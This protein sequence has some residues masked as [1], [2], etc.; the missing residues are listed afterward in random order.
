MSELTH[1]P[2]A[3]VGIGCRFPGADDH[4]AFWRNVLEGRTAF[5]PVPK[6]RWDHRAFFSASQRE[7]D[8]TW[9]LQGAFIDDVRSFAALHYGI[10]PRRIEVMDPQHRLL[11]EA[12]RIAM[13]DAGYELRSFDRSRTGVFTGLT[14]AEFKNL[15]L[16]RIG[17]MQ[18][19]SGEFGPAAGSKELRAILMEMARNVV[20]LRAFSI[21]GSLTNMAAASIAQTFDFGGPAYSI[22]AACAAGAVSI[23]DAII[24]LRAGLLDTAFAGGAY[25]NLTPDNLI[26][27]ARVGA[28]SPSGACRP[29]DHRADG[30]VQGDGVGVLMLKRLDDALEAGD[31]IYGVIRGVGCNNDARGEG[32]MTPRVEGQLGA[33]IAAYRDARV[34]PSTVAYFE[35][36]GTATR[37]GDPVEV[38]ALGQL[39]RDAGVSA[40]TAPL[41]GSVKGNIGHTMSAAGVA[42]LINGLKMLEHR[43][44]PPLAGYET[45]HPAI[46]LERWPLRLQRQASEL[47]AQDGGPLRVGV[48]AFGFG[49]TNVHFVVDE[50]PE[51]YRR[52]RIRSTTGVET[53]APSWPEAVVVT[54]PSLDLLARHAEDLAAAIAGPRADTATLAEIAW[55]LNATRR[56]ERMRLVVT[57]RDREQLARELREAATLLRA[58]PGLRAPAKLSPH[59]QLFEGPEG[60]H[61]P[62]PKLCFLFPGQGAQRVGLLRDLRQRLPRFA[63]AFA[64]LEAACASVTPRPLS[65][66]LWPELDPGDARALAEAEDALTATE[67]CQPAMAAL[68]L[69]LSTV[70]AEAGVTADVSLGHSLGEFVAMANG[71]ILDFAETVRLVARRGQA[72]AALPIEDKGAMAAVTAPA[73]EVLA[74]I[75]D[76]DG[77]WVCNFNHP[78]QV[79]ISGTTAGV[80]GA[81]ER[82]RANRIG[83]QPLAVSH[84]FHSP[85]LEPMQPAM[86]ALSREIEVRPPV[87]AVASC[88]SDRLHSSDAQ[89]SHRVMLDHSTA[90]VHFVR[91]LEQARAAGAEVFVQVGA[92]AML[93]SFARATLSKEGVETLNLSPTEPD[94]G[95][96]LMRGLAT[97]AAMGFPVRF[98]AVFPS[99]ARHVLD[100][101]A[102]PLQRE[103]YWLIKSE[104][105][106]L[107]RLEHPLPEARERFGV[108]DLAM[109]NANE[110]LETSAPSAASP[111]L[112]ALFTRQAEILRQHADII[113]AQNR[114]L[115]QGSGAAS[116]APGPAPTTTSPASLDVREAT[117]PVITPPAAVAPPPASDVESRVLEIVAKV[118]AFPK[119]SL[120]REQRLVDELGFDSLM[121]ADL[122]KAL[123]AAFPQLGGLPQS[124]FSARTTLGDLIAHVTSQAARPRHAEPAEGSEPEPLRCYRVVPVEGPPVRIERDLTGETWIT[125]ER[126][127]ALGGAMTAAL[128]RA[129]AEV[130][131]F[132]LTTETNAVPERVE[133]GALHLWPE[134]SIDQLLP[135]LERSGRRVRGA[136]YLAG[137]SGGALDGESPLPALHAAVRRARIPCLIVIT[138]LGGRLGLE[139]S[140]ALSSGLLQAGL[141]GYVK[142]L[143]RER[144]T[145]V[146]RAIDI[147][148][149]APDAE[150]IVAEILSGD[151]EP[152]VGL[153]GGRRWLPA[154]I[155]EPAAAPPRVIGARDVVLITGGSGDLGQQL[156]RALARRPLAGLV[157]LGRRPIDPT[158]SRLIAELEQLG[159]QSRYVQADVTDRAGLTRALAP[160]QA[161]LGTITCVVHAAGVIDDATVEKKTRESMERVWATKVGGL[162]AISAALPD[163]ERMVLFSSWAARFGNPGQTDYAAA[164]EVLG[165]AA[166]ALAD[167]RAILAVDWPPWSGT[168]MARSVAAPMKAAML[169][170]GVPFVGDREGAAMAE[171]LVSS[172][173]TGLLLVGR[174]VP[175][176]R[177]RAG[178]ALTLSLDSHPYLDDHRLRGEPVLPLA[179]A[180]DL[181][182]DLGMG[183]LQTG[184]GQHA[185]VEDLELV[186]GVVVQKPR[187]VTVRLQAE[188]ESAG[189]VEIAVND[190]SGDSPVAYRAN[191]RMADASA[192]V[193]ALSLTGERAAPPV[194]LET[195]YR[196][197]T[198]HGPRMQGILQIERLTDRGIE[199]M[200][201]P[202]SPRA[203]IPTSPRT[204][205]AID[206][207]VLDASFQLAGY[208]ALVQL[209]RAGYPIGFRRLVQQRPF[210]EEP[211]R[212]TVVVKSSDRDR[213]VG[214]IR[215]S[216]AH[217][218][219]YAIL[220]GVEGRFLEPAVGLERDPGT[221]GHHNGN[222]KPKNGDTVQSHAEVS[223]ERCEIA[224]FPEVEALEQRLEMAKLI[225]LQNPYFALHEG[226]ARNRSVVEGV[227]MINF[228]SYNYLGFSGH[229]EVIAAAQEAIARYGTSVSAS[230]V[231]SGERPIHRQLERGLAEHLGV[232]DAV[233]LVSGHATNVTTIGTLLGPEDVVVHD[234]LI[235]ESI[236]AGIRQSGAARRPYPHASYDA[237]DRTLG[238]VRGAYRRALIVAEGIYSMDGDICDLPRLIE[239]KKRH[240]ALL[241]IDEA[242]S[243]GV[244]GP[245]GEGVGHHF[246]G[247]DPR[248]VDIWMGTLSKSF[249]SCGGYIAGSTALVR[250]L[251]YSAG[252]FVYSAGITPPNCA[253]A[254]KA[255]ELMRRQPE[256]V[257]RLRK[258]S[259]LFLELARARGLDTGLAVGAAVV[260]VIV[261]NSI[262]ALQLGAALAKRRVNVNPIV[263]PAVEDDAAR[264]RFFLSATHTEDEV[265]LAVEA[266]AEE[267][268]RIREGGGVSASVPELKGS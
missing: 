235:H 238:Q 52:R 154:L 138:G 152:E 206:P 73:E 161:Q 172:A 118:S 223:A 190:P 266:T 66:Y 11:I 57:A 54:A 86:V 182:L 229:P 167:R 91:G 142:A 174:V 82:L 180:T 126:R 236:L 195:F 132:E 119:G 98:E 6:D 242:H 41:L 252:G 110:D 249:A 23:Y 88:I 146:I 250:F 127:G 254:L 100:L 185:V 175:R 181:L 51:A 133:R 97:L 33:L 259:R 102:T 123:D 25:L 56:F 67:I 18:L 157:L 50:P 217:G 79:S 3:V 187:A 162:A 64:A 2:V 103:Q 221:N 120:E 83:V 164:N 247:V 122:A 153:A 136:V 106:I 263:Y 108:V 31:R 183:A 143:S 177:P 111:E 244:L 205:W 173:V 101:P 37:V 14:V 13:Q 265:R 245:R 139:P 156:A 49:G 257:E 107:S 179:A 158:L 117:P 189:R 125:V 124:V 192:G 222:G 42:G 69:A 166:I 20:P 87:H 68:G 191:I 26:G 65:S 246:S 141:L 99:D 150:Q 131:R 44:A 130:L 60:E 77:V 58:E 169:A 197:H 4:H 72:M 148:P 218:V 27:F 211:V 32:P 193:P 261:G 40:R 121:V 212:C 36:H 47:V 255:L 207:L 19:A 75:G 29:F 202:S 70:L 129:G 8:K 84:A 140:A 233:V 160:V 116:T 53:S 62:P 89:H 81:I 1:I 63:A 196:E 90:P 104:P 268:A 151:L 171:A 159:T 92:G 253:A 137:L 16:A 214:D 201:R 95:L 199:G 55:T 34:S 35:A 215:Y 224:Q 46:Q 85:L 7:V 114:L 200:V 239:L 28:I 134:A 234:S 93:T 15:A 241:M 38:E 216:D 163:L 262:H 61:R 260:P 258:T 208:W 170:A 243:I 198:F 203:L 204:A 178:R 30:F 219:P 225:G 45:P 59:L 43:V 105:Q 184:P 228:S 22:D 128:E 264:L 232:E 96:E 144:P 176:R 256:T 267:L 230:R 251:K 145:D 115:L 94:G 71:G 39:L 9:A 78:R 227:E 80:A 209:Q 48:S 24:H 168:T 147:D 135:G 194:D 165:R 112:V 74:I 113:A 12:T 226:T 213:F 231:A 109:A 220:E 155:A 186:R 17:A 10:P 149:A 76:L 240:R 21:P 188:S 237:L 210:G 248:D 5:A